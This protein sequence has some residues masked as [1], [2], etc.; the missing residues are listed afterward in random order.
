MICTFF[1]FIEIS[2]QSFM[3]P[4]SFKHTSGA[5]IISLN[6]SLF[7]PFLSALFWHYFPTL[8]TPHTPD[9]SLRKAVSIAF[10]FFVFVTINSY[11][12]PQHQCK[13]D[14]TPDK[15]HYTCKLVFT[16]HNLCQ[17]MSNISNF[18][19]PLV[20]F[21]ICSFI[22]AEN[23]PLILEFYESKFHTM[24]SLSQRQLPCS[25]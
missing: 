23:I 8:C 3:S 11:F 2:L 17:A 21:V 20:Y 12:F 19:C 9:P 18:H 22:F 7:H 10:P 25:C 24:N 13:L 15:F 1:C 14:Y 6:F 16:S 5:L 4:H